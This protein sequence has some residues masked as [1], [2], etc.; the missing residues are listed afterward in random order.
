MENAKGQFKIIIKLFYFNRILWS[1]FK[2]IFNRNTISSTSRKAY[3]S[4]QIIYIDSG[5]G[6]KNDIK[7]YIIIIL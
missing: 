5:F 7:K 1:I 3:I 4:T 2:F 6:Y